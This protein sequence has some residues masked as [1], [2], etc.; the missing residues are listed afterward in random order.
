[1]YL[2][3][4]VHYSLWIP[5]RASLH[6]QAI[7]A[8]TPTQEASFITHEN[9]ASFVRVPHGWVSLGLGPLL[10]GD[11]EGRARAAAGYDWQ[12]PSGATR[13][14]RRRSA[15]APVSCCPFQLTKEV[16]AWKVY[17]MYLWA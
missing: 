12:L 17:S 15:P 8:S 1:M 9:K 4:R 14:C 13:G 10:R 7:G 11:S 2:L 3:H 5:Y 6:L 16:K